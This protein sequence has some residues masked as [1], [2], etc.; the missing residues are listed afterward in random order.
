MLRDI[1]ILSFLTIF[2]L[3]VFLTGCNSE[4]G[5]KNTGEKKEEV[6]KNTEDEGLQKPQKKIESHEEALTP[7]TPKP[8]KPQVNPKTSPKSDGNADKNYTLIK[9]IHEAES[10]KSTPNLI[11]KSVSYAPVADLLSKIEQDESI[12]LKSRGEAHITI[13]SPLEFKKLKPHLSIAQIEKAFKDDIVKSKFD[14]KCLGRAEKIINGKMEQVFYIV[15]ESPEIF[16]IRD[17]I[18]ALFVKKGG[19]SSDFDPKIFYPHI[20]VGFSERDLHPSDGVTKDLSSCV[21]TLMP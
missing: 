11:Q 3:F 5:S 20:T 17:K 19:K 2:S 7:T 13:I 4:E 6:Q 18:H 15:V 16:D 1:Y 8:P 9:D 21:A 10:F 12:K 14:V